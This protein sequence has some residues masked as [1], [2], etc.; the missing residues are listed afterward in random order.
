MPQQKIKIPIRKKFKP[1]ERELIAQEIIDYIVNRTKKGKDK[2]E[3]DFPGYSKEYINSKDFSIAGKSRANVNLTL[4]SEMLDSLKLLRHSPG[5][6]VIGYD[7]GDTELNGKVEGN[8]K[9]TYGQ[10]TPRRGK[11]RD[12]LGITRDKR[13]EIQNQYDTS[14]VD[15]ATIMERIARLK[16]VTGDGEE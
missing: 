14:K 16:A 13:V 1:Q 10:S 8:I 4:T 5:E 3:N 15:R 2:N 12:F 11:K 6:I 9:G 7:K